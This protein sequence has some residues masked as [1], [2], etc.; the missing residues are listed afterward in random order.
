M[1]SVSQLCVEQVFVKDPTIKFSNI[2]WVLKCIIGFL[3]QNLRALPCLSHIVPSPLEIIISGASGE[4]I[5]H[6]HHLTITTVKVMAKSTTQENYHFWACPKARTEI[7][8]VIGTHDNHPKTPTPICPTLSKWDLKSSLCI[9][10]TQTQNKIRH[11]TSAWSS[12][13]CRQELG[14]PSDGVK[15]DFPNHQLFHIEAVE[16]TKVNNKL[17]DMDKW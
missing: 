4:T 15:D 8:V 3:S 11:L 17:E 1:L 16:S 9:V 13:S 2:A 6:T 7:W 12:T 5:V 14:E 10:T